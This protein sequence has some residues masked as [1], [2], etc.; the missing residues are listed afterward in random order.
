V[1]HASL[2]HGRLTHLTRRNKDHGYE[3][4]EAQM[5]ENFGAKTFLVF[6]GYIVDMVFPVLGI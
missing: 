4:S 5:V 6:G 1:Y 3:I 2:Q